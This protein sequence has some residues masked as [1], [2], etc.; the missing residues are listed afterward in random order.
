MGLIEI[1]RGCCRLAKFEV[2]G[3]K[4]ITMRGMR[5]MA[6]LLHKTL[7]EEEG[8]TQEDDYA[9]SHGFNLDETL[10]ENAELEHSRCS[11]R[12]KYS[13]EMLYMQSNG[14]GFWSKSWDKLRYLS[15]WI[16]VGELLTPLPMAGL[17]DCPNLEEIKIRIEGDCRG[18][19][20]LSS[21]HLDRAA[22]PNIPGCQDA[23][24]LQRHNRLCI[25]CPIWTNGFE[26][27]GEVFLEWDREFE[28]Q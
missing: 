15:L 24:G 21:V 1:A 19:H 2:E 18:R 27:V 10:S 6:C 17:D 7:V 3:C 26:L 13:A 8:G 14:D 4:K 20:R 16:G 22:L 11:K 12:I 23:V 25:N 5:T 28:P 9:A